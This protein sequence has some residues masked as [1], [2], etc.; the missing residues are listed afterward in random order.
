MLA[1]RVIDTADTNPFP[2]TVGSV[3]LTGGSF[4]SLAIFI[5]FNHGVILTLLLTLDTD[6]TLHPFGVAEAGIAFPYSF[7]IGLIPIAGIKYITLT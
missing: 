1:V 4:I 6:I 2:D 3:V 5:A 7:E